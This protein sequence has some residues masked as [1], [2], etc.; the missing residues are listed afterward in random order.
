LWPSNR[1]Y[2][3]YV[4]FGRWSMAAVFFVTHLKENVAF[5]VVEECEIPQNRNVCADQ[6]IC[7]TGPE[8]RQIQ[9]CCAASSFGM[10]TKSVRSLMSRI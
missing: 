9:T 3:D 5:A 7:L 8:P 1:G 4:L 6:F 2:I 10:P